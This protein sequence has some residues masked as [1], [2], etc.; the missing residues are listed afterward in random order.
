MP[1]IGFSVTSQGI[2]A[3]SLFQSIRQTPI[4][5][6][7]FARADPDAKRQFE[8]AI[9]IS[10]KLAQGAKDA[11]AFATTKDLEAKKAR[12]KLLKMLAQSA[13]DPR[14][15]R[16]IAREVAEIARSLGNAAA[17]G[18]G[19]GG[20][21]Q[22]NATASVASG[23]GAATLDNATASVA[24]GEGAATLDA[25]SGT[26][27][28]ASDAVVAT[29][30]GAEGADAEEGSQTADTAAA[31]SQGEAVAA[32]GAGGA[33]PSIKE[34]VRELL[35]LA[36]KILENLRSKVLPGSRASEEIEKANREVLKAA[37]AFGIS[38]DGSSDP[39]SSPEGGGSEAVA[40]GSDLSLSVVEVT[41]VAS[42]NIEV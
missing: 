9:N 35:Q 15:I 8:D 21:V 25:A 36:K 42:I 28:A 17:S 32:P 6:D 34:Q 30:A 27:A 39:A 5:E 11:Q 37:S 20:M 23:E 33:D 19:G 7:V 4:K 13:T 26:E 22:A 2:G 41:T 1:N 18:G 10:K 24:S 16:A 31:Q 12:L 40:V 3:Q 38:L 29:G 14:T